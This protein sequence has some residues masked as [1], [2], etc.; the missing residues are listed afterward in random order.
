VLTGILAG[1]FVNFFSL[2]A[3]T[4]N[5]VSN[6]QEINQNRRIIL[7]RVGREIRQAGSITIT[8]S[9]DITFSFD[10]DYDG[11]DEA[12]RYYLSGNELHKT[13]DASGDTVVLENVNSLSFSG[14][15][16][17]IV[18]LITILKDGQSSTIETSFLRRQSL[19]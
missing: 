17:R 5:L 8:S 2:G 1:L 13:I 6:S 16:S 12:V 11:A 10:V 19:S 9:T 18:V 4:F 15:S 14:N 3:D 7:E